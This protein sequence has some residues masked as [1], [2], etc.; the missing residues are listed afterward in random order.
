MT[1]YV[2]AVKPT[3]KNE[4]LTDTTS[5]KTVL[6]Q[7]VWFDQSVLERNNCI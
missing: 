7:E 6:Q 1:E 3:T 4:K 5:D 2:Q